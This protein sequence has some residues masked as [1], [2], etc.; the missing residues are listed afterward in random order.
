MNS[1]QRFLHGTAAELVGSP[2]EMWLSGVQGRHQV[3]Q[4]VL[5]EGRDGLATALLLLAAGVLALVA[6]LAGMVGK[7]FDRQP[8]DRSIL[9][10]ILFNY[11]LVFYI[12][13]LQPRFFLT[14]RKR[15]K[16]CL[17]FYLCLG[18][19]NRGRAHAT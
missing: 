18:K 2:D 19:K 9:G 16:N 12:T 10:L 13:L 5:V 1:N 6:G 7:D 4:L 11:T 17:L 8:V 15:N 3:V 14:R